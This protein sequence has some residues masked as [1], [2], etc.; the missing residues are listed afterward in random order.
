MKPKE[1]KILNLVQYLESQKYFKETDKGSPAAESIIIR[2][3]EDHV[4]YRVEITPEG[5]RFW[6][7]N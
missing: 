1:K 6:V 5:V 2:G 4:P 3:E 7:I